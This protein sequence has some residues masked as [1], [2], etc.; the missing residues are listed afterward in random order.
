MKRIDVINLTRDAVAQ[1]MG[2]AYMESLGE[3]DYMDSYKLVDIGRDVLG[4]STRESFSKALISLLGKMVIDERSYENDIKSIFVDSFD[5]GG[6][7][8]RVY[9]TPDQ[10]IEDDMFNLVNGKVYD[11]S[12]KF[13]Q[14]GVKAKIFEESKGFMIPSSW[15][16]ETLK[17]AFTGWDKMNKFLSGR[18]TMV[19]NTL[20]LALSSYAHMLVSCAIA[21]ANNNGNAFHAITEAIAEGVIPSG[22][23][24]DVARNSE[25]FNIFVMRRISEIRDE[26]RDYGTGHNNGEIPT[27]TPD[28][29]N[30]MLLLSK[31]AND[32]NFVARRNAYNLSEIG[33]GDFEKITKWQGY[34]DGTSKYAFDDVSKIMISADSDNKLGLGTEAVTVENAVGLIFDHRA[35]GL[36]PYKEKTTSNYVGSADFWNEYLHVLLNYILDANYSMVAVMYD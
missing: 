8:E 2:D 33:I 23:T 3:L 14:P 35:I 27:F 26:M 5:W 32:F 12:L 25:A 22:T 16:E 18:K 28:D 7:V 13:F 34:T 20:K 19:R 30:K 24:A 1:T 36:C 29:D 17:E 9:F 11:N 6:F 4:T 31:V 21:V 15:S 10:I